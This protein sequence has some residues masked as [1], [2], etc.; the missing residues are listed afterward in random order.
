MES[1]QVPQPVLVAAAAP[2]RTGQALREG[3][4]QPG[5]VAGSH[6][7]QPSER[8]P[9]PGNELADAGAPEGDGARPASATWPPARIALGAA[10]RAGNRLAPALGRRV[11]GPRMSSARTL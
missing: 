8:E 1:G 2:G 11:A 9:F 6:G 3:Q 4:P 5:V 7:E 10:G